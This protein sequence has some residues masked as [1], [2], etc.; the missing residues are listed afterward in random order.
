MGDDIV[1]ALVAKIGRAD[2]GLADLDIVQ[3]QRRDLRLAGIDLGSR[4]I[5]SE[6]PAARQKPGHRD[7]VRAAGA[8]Q[9]EHPAGARFRAFDTVQPGQHGKVVRVGFTHRLAVVWQRLVGVQGRTLHKVPRVRGGAIVPAAKAG[10]RQYRPVRRSVGSGA[11]R[12]DIVNQGRRG[13][14]TVQRFD[15]KDPMPASQGVQRIGW[16]RQEGIG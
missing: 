12:S 1:E 6:K 16:A 11:R 7:Q 13:E 10:C 14:D 9:L 2:I 15:I 8:A 4:Q 3:L 5:E